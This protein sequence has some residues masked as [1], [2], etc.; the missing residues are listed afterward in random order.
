ME[1]ICKPKANKQLK[2][3]TTTGV[4]VTHFFIGCTHTKDDTKEDVGG[5]VVFTFYLQEVMPLRLAKSCSTI[6]LFY[7]CG[8]ILPEI[9]KKEFIFSKVTGLWTVTLPKNKLF[10]NCISRTLTTEEGQ[11]FYRNMSMWLLPL[12]TETQ[13]GPSIKYVHKIFSKNYH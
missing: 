3:H 1:W 10:Y 9:P 7:H 2:W 4:S 13:K 11:L 8:Q 5:F 6:E 12:Q